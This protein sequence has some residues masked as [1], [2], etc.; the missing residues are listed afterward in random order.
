MYWVFK[1]PKV[2]QEKRVLQVLQDLLDHLNLAHQDQ[3]V[4]QELEVSSTSL[5]P[6]I[7]PRIRIS[8]KNLSSCVVAGPRGSLGHPGKPGP[9]CKAPLPGSQGDPGILGPDGEQGQLLIFRF[10]HLRD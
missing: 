5:Y 7:H 9:D 8:V 3:K 2:F 1:D 4:L 10:N 6:L